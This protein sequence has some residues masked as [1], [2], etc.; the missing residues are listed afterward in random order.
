MSF[1]PITEI[2]QSSRE[3]E[4]ARSIAQERLH[5]IEDLYRLAPQAMGMIGPDH[6]LLRC[7]QLLADLAESSI[8]A[9]RDAPITRVMAQ[10][11][12]DAT[13]SVQTVFQTG[14]P[15]LSQE[16]IR[17]ESDKSEDPETWEIDWYPISQEE[18][19]TAVAVT[20][21]TSRDTRPCRLSCS[22]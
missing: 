21:A 6:R 4:R 9:L 18:R 2:R 10:F 17:Y 16:A 3:L 22:A 12:I 14:E 5:E 8:G 19:V 20:V 1:T 11:G 13:Q 15:V 7:N